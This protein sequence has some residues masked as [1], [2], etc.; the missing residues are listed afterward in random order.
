M[1]EHSS[2][3][4]Q[5]LEAR[6]ARIARVFGEAV[7]QVSAIPAEDLESLY[8]TLTLSKDAPALVRELARRAAIQY[9]KRGEVP[10]PHVRAALRS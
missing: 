6:I 2:Y 4:D 7:E 8:G 10:P 9:I 3:E 5:N 1:T